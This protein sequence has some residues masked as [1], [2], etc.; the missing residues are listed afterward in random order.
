MNNDRVILS[1]LEFGETERVILDKCLSINFLKERYTPYSIFKGSFYTPEFL[2]EI[3]DIEVTVNGKLIHKGV[4]DRCE[5]KQLPSHR[6]IT[7]SSKGYTF[8]LG[9]TELAEEIRYG[10]SLNSLMTAEV[11][12]PFVS[13]EQ[14]SVTASYLFIKEHSTLWDAIVN[15]SLK[16][17]QSYPYIVYTNKVKFSKPANPF[18]HEFSDADVVTSFSF[19]NDFANLISDIHMRGSDGE[20]NS[21]NA[22]LPY[23][24]ERNIERHKHVAFD[25]QWLSDMATGLSYRLKFCMRGLGFKSVTYKGF[26]GEDINDKFSSG[27]SG[28]ETTALD[29]SAVEIK[30]GK[31]G[32]FT[33]LTA[34]RDGYCNNA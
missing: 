22:E 5:Q 32:V 24:Q 8:S 27:I 26:V 31:S 3:V 23:A 33:T 10:L 19:G 14:S 11:T 29:I 9:Y 13:C 18:V 28:F 30:G 7:L 12:P 1:V 6:V 2:G 21:Y 16:A 17:L 20:Y 25:K 15:L 4:I 34:Y